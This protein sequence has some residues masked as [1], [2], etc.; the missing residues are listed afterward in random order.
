MTQTFNGGKRCVAVAPGQAGV[1]RP[2]GFPLPRAR[3]AQPCPAPPTH[4]PRPGLSATLRRQPEPS[5][6]PRGDTAR[7]GKGGTDGSTRVPDSPW[8][9]NRERAH[10]SESQGA[11]NARCPG[12]ASWAPRPGPKVG[13]GG[14]HWWRVGT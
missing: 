6:R 8:P 4:R 11:G 1:P 14:G 2:P 10:S 12:D 13:S 3:P 5:R 7:A 9:K